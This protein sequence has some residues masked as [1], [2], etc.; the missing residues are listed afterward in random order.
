MKKVIK[1]SFNL[2]GLDIVKIKQE[3]SSKHQFPHDLD[4]NFVSLFNKNKHLLGGFTPK[5]YTTYKITEYLTKNQI[6]GDFIECGVYKGR[7]IVMMALTLL[8]YGDSKREIYLYDTFSGMTKPG[9]K[10]FKKHRPQVETSQKN[11]SKWKNMQNED[12]NLYCYAP[13]DL[14]KKNVFETGYPKDK[15]HFEKGDVLKTIPNSSHEKISFLRLDTDWYELTKHELFHLYPLVVSNG[16]V[17]IDDYGSWQ[18]AREAID[19]FFLSEKF[20]PL[21]FRT[22]PSERAF[23]KSS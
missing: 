18:G 4:D 19:E 23:V 20:C 2:L 3:N 7:Q 1:K 12:H 16:V 15:I 17:S 9:E 6:P 11:L 22:G 21:L 5:L 13:M 14:V 8:K 10:D